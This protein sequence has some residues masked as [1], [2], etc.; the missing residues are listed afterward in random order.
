MPAHV[1]SALQLHDLVLDYVTALHS[2]GE[3]RELHIAI[4]D[5]FCN[6]RTKTEAGTVGWSR[7]HR[8]DAA[9]NYVTH[10]VHHHVRHARGG[11]S[12]DAILSWATDHV[13]DCISY[14]A[15]GELGEDRLAAAAA[16]AEAVNDYYASACRWDL[17]AYVRKLLL[18]KRDS[19]AATMRCVHCIGTTQRVGLSHTLHV[20]TFLREVWRQV[21]RR[22]SRAAHRHRRRGQRAARQVSPKRLLDETLWLNFTSE[23]QRF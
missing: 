3:L 8:G 22:E 15:A 6:H 7:S 11:A 14:A 9:T 16:E 18:G 23:C 5:A 17:A 13:Q 19:D 21:A 2:E 10:E 4:V 1:P 20:W 12:D